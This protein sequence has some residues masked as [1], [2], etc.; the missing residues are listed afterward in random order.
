[1]IKLNGHEV[2]ATIFPDKTS[3]IWQLPVDKV[4]SH[5]Q[6][7]EWQFENEAEIMHVLQLADLCNTC[8]M[9]AE[10]VSLHIQTMPYARQDKSINNANTFALR[11]FLSL[12]GRSRFKRITTVDIHNPKVLEGVYEDFIINMM[13]NERIKQ[14]I[15]DVRP[16]L[17][18]FPDYGASQRGYNTQN[19]PHFTLDKKRNQTTGEIEGLKTTL[20]LKLEGLTILLVDDLCDGGR[21]FIEAANLLYNLGAKEVSLYTTHGIYSK[22]VKVLKDAKLKRVFNYTEEV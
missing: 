21:T 2:K 10:R 6:L 14:V 18:C 13:P 20:P 7:I 11:T 4:V 19:I 17:I 8:T 12:L 22:G 15:E 5:E 1:M 3:Q 9:G 16:D